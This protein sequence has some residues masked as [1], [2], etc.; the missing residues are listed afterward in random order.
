MLNSIVY[1]GTRIGLYGYVAP[2]TF[3]GCGFDAPRFWI[4]NTMFVSINHCAPIKRK[5]WIRTY[6]WISY[7]N[8][9]ILATGLYQLSFKWLLRFVM[10]SLRNQII[11][12]NINEQLT[13][14]WWMRGRGKS[15]LKRK[16]KCFTKLKNKK[17]RIRVRLFSFSSIIF[18]R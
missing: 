2:T 10:M 16:R 3:K 7:T 13:N 17:L 6:Q 14:L 15:K 18:C 1:M 12:K 5:F 11:L 8:I 4:F 9:F